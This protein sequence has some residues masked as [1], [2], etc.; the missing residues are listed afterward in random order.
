MGSVFSRF[1][2][3]KTQFEGSLFKYGLGHTKSVFLLKAALQLVTREAFFPKKKDLIKRI[4]KFTNLNSLYI[5]LFNPYWRVRAW[6]HG[7]RFLTFWY[8]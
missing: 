8:Y 3:I 7:K 6:P 5:M 1:G 2:I 4:K